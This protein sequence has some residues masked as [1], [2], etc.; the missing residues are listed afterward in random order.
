MKTVPVEHKDT[1]GTLL[2]NN[3]FPLWE[4]AQ[5]VYEKDTVDSAKWPRWITY[6]YKLMELQCAEVLEGRGLGVTE[7]E[8]EQLSCYSAFRNACESMKNCLAAWTLDG[9]DT[10]KGLDAN[11]PWMRHLFIGTIENSLADRRQFLAW[12]DSYCFNDTF[13]AY[14]K[15]PPGWP[16]SPSLDSDDPLAFFRLSTTHRDRVLPGG[17]VLTEITFIPKP[18]LHGMRAYDPSRDKRMD[19]KRE[20][21]RTFETE[22]QEGRP[23]YR[24]VSKAHFTREMDDHIRSVLVLAEETG[25]FEKK[26]GKEDNKHFWLLAQYQIARCSKS[27]LVGYKGE[28]QEDGNSLIEDTGGLSSTQEAIQ[29]TAELVGVPL[30]SCAGNRDE[31]K[32]SERKKIEYFIRTYGKEPPSRRKPAEVSVARKK[33]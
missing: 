3:L 6:W 4:E 5:E 30:R 23:E 11:V 20:M 31:K 10:D 29:R 26:K 7:Q 14:P 17:A 1:I 33:K 32:V 28:F 16:D 24:K 27:E 15:R 8:F 2:K 12:R 19:W 9:Y 13:D 22:K 25:Y 18:W 21:M